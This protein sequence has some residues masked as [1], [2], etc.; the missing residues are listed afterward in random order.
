[1]GTVDVDVSEYQAF[2][3]RLKTVERKVQN[4]LRKRLRDLAK[5][6]TQKVRDEGTQPMPSRGG[7]NGNLM[8]ARIST[9]I[10]AAGMSLMLGGRKHR[11]GEGQ[12]MQIDNDGIL[13]HPIWARAER[14]RKSWRWTTQ[15]V[16]QGTYTASFL[17]QRDEIRDELG[18]E[19]AD[20]MREIT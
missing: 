12:L 16:P 1:M 18:K 6:V 8:T 5:P 3:A 9:S 2:T 15:A 17:A 11:G 19:I 14:P 13:R 10:T 20:I 7:L 4:G